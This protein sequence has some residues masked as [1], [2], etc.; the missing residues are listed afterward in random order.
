MLNNFT[1]TYFRKKCGVLY[2]VC[3]LDRGWYELIHNCGR[4]G[5]SFNP[6]LA[7]VT[8]NHTKSSNSRW[9]KSN[10][11]GQKS[12]YLVVGLF[13]ALHCSATASL[14]CLWDEGANICS[15]QW[16]AASP[17]PKA[18]SL[19]Q[20]SSRS[21]CIPIPWTLKECR[22]WLHWVGPAFLWPLWTSFTEHNVWG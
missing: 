20:L 11:P 3:Y 16:W 2:T 5:I 14:L 17:L 18:Q 21:C 4:H 12:K 1:E 13:C 7:A 15:N 8:S 10:S 22:H 19:Q 9:D 6:A